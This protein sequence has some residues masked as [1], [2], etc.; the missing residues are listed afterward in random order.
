MQGLPTIIVAGTLI[1][2]GLG[3]LALTIHGLY[4]AFSASIILGILVLFIE[5]AP[6][7]ISLCYLLS[8]INLAEE[9]VK[10]F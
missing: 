6:F 10:L 5:P 7:I 9:I 4:L 3:V 8:G 2:F 1:T